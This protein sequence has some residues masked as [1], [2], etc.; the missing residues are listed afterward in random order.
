MDKEF[1]RLTLHCKNNKKIMKEFS[2]LEEVIATQLTE[3]LMDQF[4]ITEQKRVKLREIQAEFTKKAKLK[5]FKHRL[6]PL[7][8]PVPR[9]NQSHKEIREFACTGPSTEMSGLLEHAIKEKI[10][11]RGLAK[12]YPKIIDNI[13]ADAK[14][15][16]VRITHQMGVSGIFFEKLIPI[17]VES[18]DLNISVW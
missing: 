11:S 2:P 1:Q 12:K 13:M 14:V 3:G 7:Y 8:Q 17:I 15:E 6:L 5:E 9:F 4:Q 10:C 16:F 18:V